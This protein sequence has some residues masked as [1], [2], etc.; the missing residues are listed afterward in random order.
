M[1][2]KFL[3]THKKSDAKASDFFIQTAVGMPV[4]LAIPLS[5]GQYNFE[6]I[7]LPDRRIKQKKHCFRS[8]FLWKDYEKD[9][10]LKADELSKK[11]G[12]ILTNTHNFKECKKAYP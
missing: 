11:M 6:A 7:K 1:V 3:I 5:A 12:S 4:G 8:A 9:T 2:S 10:K